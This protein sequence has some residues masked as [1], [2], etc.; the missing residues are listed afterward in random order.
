MARLVRR[1][2][3]VELLGSRLT[4]VDLWHLGVGGSPRKE[5]RAVQVAS[6]F[7]PTQA[8]SNHVAEFVV[9]PGSVGNVGVKVAD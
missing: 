5:R 4:L 3:S 7:S 9:P 1:H 2:L 6:G 8:L